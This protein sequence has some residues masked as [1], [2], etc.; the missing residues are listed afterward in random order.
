MTGFDR[1]RL[2]RLHEVIASH[3]ERDTVGGVAW[4]AARDGEVEAGVAGTL[5]TLPLLYQPG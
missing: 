4:L 3:V 1:A 5:S 2:G